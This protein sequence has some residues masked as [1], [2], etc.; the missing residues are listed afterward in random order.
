[1]KRRKPISAVPQEGSDS[2]VDL[3]REQE[4]LQEQLAKIQAKMDMK[5]AKG[6][7][8]RGTSP[9]PSTCTSRPSLIPSD[10]STAA[11]PRPSQC[12]A[13]SQTTGPMNDAPNPT[14]ATKPAGARPVAAPLRGRGRSYSFPSTVCDDDYDP[15]E[16]ENDCSSASEEERDA[17]GKYRAARQV[18][19]SGRFG[20]VYDPKTGQDTCLMFRNVFQNQDPTP[21]CSL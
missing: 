8:T 14:Q 18:L 20:V 21:A 6:A 11:R 10:R 2:D 13:D 15:K 16:E 17:Q 12:K 1:M 5:K 19:N 7:E 3:K 9:T 4:N